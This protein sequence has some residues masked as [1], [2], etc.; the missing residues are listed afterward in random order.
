MIIAIH[1]PNFFP[2][3]PFFRK[4]KSV[5]KF[6]ILTNCQFEKNGYQN[7]FRM[8]GR[9]QTMSVERGLTTSIHGK[10]Y[11]DVDKDWAAIKSRLSDYDKVLS[12]F[13]EDISSS[14]VETNIRI[15]RRINSIFGCETDVDLDY[16]TTLTGTERLVDIVRHYGGTTYLS[17]SSGKEYLD[18]EQFSHAGIE[19]VYQD[20]NLLT[21]GAMLPVI[22]N[23]LT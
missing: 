4:M 7:R 9:W 3:T 13:D 23:R 16:P 11:V 17:G 19:V 2:W 15:I 8:N 18:E 20:L 1:Q 5:D 21:A 10:R 12:L 22:K 6:I 14:L